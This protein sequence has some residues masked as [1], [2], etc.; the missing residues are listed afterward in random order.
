MPHDKTKYIAQAVLILEAVMI[1]LM[2]FLAGV[3]VPDRISVQIR[4]A[5][6]RSLGYLETQQVMYAALVLAGFLIVH[7]YMCW[8]WKVKESRRRYVEI[9]RW[10]NIIFLYGSTGLILFSVWILFWQIIG[11]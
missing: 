3:L 4:S 2:G 6:S 1:L 8:M 9:N 5:L 11:L 10:G 7:Q